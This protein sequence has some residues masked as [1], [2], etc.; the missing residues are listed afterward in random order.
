MRSR[1]VT[2]P[3]VC[4]SSRAST[5]VCVSRSSGSIAGRAAGAEHRLDGHPAD[6]R[7]VQRP[8]DDEA[9]LVVVDAQRCGHREGGEDTRG[10]QP[11]D[12]ALLEPP[13]VGAPVVGRRR[14]RLAVVLEV[15]LDPLAVSPQ[16]GKEIVVLGDGEAV[17]VDQHPHDRPRGDRVEELGEPRVERR[18]AAA[19]HEHVDPAVL[20]GEPGVDRRQ[21]L[22]QRRHRCECRRGLGEA[23]RALEVAVVEQVLQQDA[24]VLGL[25]LRQPVLVR[26]RY[27]K[28]VAAQVG[29]VHLRR[30]GPLLEVAEDLRRLVVQRAHEPVVGTPALQ[31]DPLVALDQPAGEPAHVGQRAVRLFFVAQR[32]EGVDVPVDPVAPERHPRRAC[33]PATA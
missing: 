26:R 1:Q 22:L 15:D 20:A 12:R 6:V 29:R 27:R 8:L 33:S 3:A 23:G 2:C 16:Q 24:R 11:L 30:R 25:H 4:S 31:P 19:E 21:H 17:G 28:E 14:G 9:D 18:L 5:P 7:R 13:D 32:A 10:G